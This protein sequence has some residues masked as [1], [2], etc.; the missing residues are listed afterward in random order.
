MNHASLATTAPAPHPAPRP[1]ASAP[2]P[3]PLR[4]RPAPFRLLQP[5]AVA[6]DP[7]D[8]VYVLDAG[9]GHVH[10]LTTDGQPVASWP[11]P[12]ATAADFAASP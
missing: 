3:V 4:E 10:K 6:V 7:A 11:V 1:L 9:S 5:V 8:R 2:I 12:D